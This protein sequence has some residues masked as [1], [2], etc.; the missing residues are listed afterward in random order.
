MHGINKGV[1]F[2]QIQA[3][4]LLILHYKGWEMLLGLRGSKEYKR[5]PVLEKEKEL[6][7]PI[8]Y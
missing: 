6:Q 4:P 1:W 5:K 3:P 2:S 7:N 8:S